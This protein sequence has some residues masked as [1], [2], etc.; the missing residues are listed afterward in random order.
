MKQIL[1]LPGS[2]RRGSY[3]RLLLQAA[4]GRAPAGVQLLMSDEI[5]EIPLFNEDLEMGESHGPEAVARLAR[6]IAEADGL[7]I[8]TPE[9]NQSIPGVV[10]NTIDWLSRPVGNE[11]LDGKPVAV[12]GATAGPWGTRIAQSVLR[13]TLT[14]TGALVLPQPQLYVPGAERLFSREGN[15]LDDALGNRLGKLLS[16]FERWIDLVTPEPQVGIR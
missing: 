10:K 13:H 5:T 11:V 15:L 3:N 14:A 4:A 12:I 16:A 1:A 2:L 9:Y 8:A 7:L 6:R